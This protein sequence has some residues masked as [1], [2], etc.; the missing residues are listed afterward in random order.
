MSDE[1]KTKTSATL[2]LLLAA[3]ASV[4]IVGFG[5]QEPAAPQ[6]PAPQPPAQQPAAAPGQRP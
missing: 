3:F 1:Q 5:A 2:A 4:A 6:P